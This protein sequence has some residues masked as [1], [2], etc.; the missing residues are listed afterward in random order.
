MGFRGALQTMLLAGLAGFGLP[1]AG[2][3]IPIANFSFETGPNGNQPGRTNGIRF[4]NLGSTAP[5][6]DTYSTL[7]GW[8]MGGGGGRVELQSNLSASLNARD[9]SNFISLDGGPGRNA[10][11]S[12]TLTLAA[13]VYALSFW[14]SPENWNA[15]TNTIS[16]NLGNVVN[17]RV[18]VGTNGAAVGVWTQIYTRFSIVTPGS[19]TLSFAALGAADGIGGFIDD[20][21]LVTTVPAPAAG[22]AGLT[23][24]LALWGV[25]RRRRRAA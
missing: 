11:I 1:A 20:V 23:G 2:A 19:Y 7:S 5:G 22:L 13:G 6:W 16:Y 15:A 12:Q 21:T 8:S 17:G 24:L 14:Y 3:T 4:N 25:K 10:S 9:G 18:T